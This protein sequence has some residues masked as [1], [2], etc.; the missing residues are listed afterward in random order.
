MLRSDKN[1]RLSTEAFGR[2]C[3]FI[4]GGVNSPVRAFGG[5]EDKPIFIAS[6]AGSKI[7]DID[8]YYCPLFFL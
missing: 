7:F 6:A 3:K 5:V 8:Y 2:A 1:N 4:P